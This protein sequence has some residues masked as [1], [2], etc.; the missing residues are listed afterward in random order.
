[1]VDLYPRLGFRAANLFYGCLRRI[2]CSSETGFGV[3]KLEIVATNKMPIVR[4]ARAATPQ[5]KFRIT[6]STRHRMTIAVANAESCLTPGLLDYARNRRK[7]DNHH[8]R[9]E[10]GSAVSG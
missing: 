10:F 9:R 2:I 4:E 6:A 5:S 8:A 1:M 3:D 7:G